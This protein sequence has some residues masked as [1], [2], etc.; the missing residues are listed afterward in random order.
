MA[1][2]VLVSLPILLR[3]TRAAMLEAGFTLRPRGPGHGISPWRILLR[4][5]LP[6]AINPLVSLFGFSL[7]SLLSASLLTE[8]VMSWPGLGPFC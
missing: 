5:A 1:V 6:V 8:V 2:L 7:G 4:H 3:H